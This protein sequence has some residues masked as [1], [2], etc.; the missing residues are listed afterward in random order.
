MLLTD[1]TYQTTACIVHCIVYSSA[2]TGCK[3]NAC[4]QV[5]DIAEGTIQSIKP[6][7]AFIDLGRGM[8]GLLHVSQIS[9]DRITNVGAILSEGDKLKVCKSTMDRLIKL[10]RYQL[11]SFVALTPAHSVLNAEC[12]S[13]STG[14]AA[15]MLVVQ[16]SGL[17]LSL[18]ACPV[19]PAV[20]MSLAWDVTSL[21]IHAPFVLHHM[22][23]TTLSSCPLVCR[24][25]HQL[26]AHASKMPLAVHL[27][28]CR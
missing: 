17:C 24:S 9:Y 19:P 12:C 7:G 22:H 18:H 5:G 6:Y 13:S 20:G 3:M 10:N 4:L 28:C 25:R 16:F 14:F 2:T 27:L 8:S 11:L 15:E 26:H 23:M 21:V 1:C